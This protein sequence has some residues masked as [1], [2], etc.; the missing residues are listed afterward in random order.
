MAVLA[1]LHAC[2]HLVVG[3]MSPWDRFMPTII[4]AILGG[5]MYVRQ[6]HERRTGGQQRR[7]GGQ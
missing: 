2:V 6:Q 5:G 7:A 1:E 3:M 4:G